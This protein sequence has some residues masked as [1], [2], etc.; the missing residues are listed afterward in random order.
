MSYSLLKY[1]LIPD[2]I[3]V[4]ISNVDDS[5]NDMGI[6]ENHEMEE[7]RNIKNEARKREF[8]NTRHLLK[9]LAEKFGYQ[10]ADFQIQK[11]E[12]GKPYALA[13]NERIYLSI[14]HTPDFILCGISA[15]KDFGLDLEPVSRRVH[16]GL[17][18]RIFHTE[19]QEDVKSLDLIRLWTIKE[20]LVKLQGGGLRTNLNDVKVMKI[21]NEQFTAI[22]NN[23]KSAKICS[24]Q[25]SEHWI[26][27][28]YF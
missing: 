6:L 13:D 4:A 18:K 7:Y 5:L 22:F 11:D 3:N 15:E 19:E 17:K 28:A 23:E 26:S 10:P 8:I 25:H 1:Q 20:A 9:S 14:A 27:V 24:F 12:L 16:E 21:G 2:E